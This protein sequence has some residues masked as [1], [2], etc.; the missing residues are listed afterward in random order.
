MP[1]ITVANRYIL[2]REL[3]SGGMGVVHCALDKL[4]NIQVALKRIKP[5]AYTPELI[6]RFKREG[7]VLHALKHPNIIQILDAF[8][9]DGQHYLVMSYLPGGNL[10]QLMKQ[11][12]LDSETVIRIGLD[13]ADAL[14]QAH[15]LKIIHRDLKPEN[16]LLDE[17]GTPFLTDFGLAQVESSERLTTTGAILGT[18]DYLP[19]EAFSDV[20]RNEK[21]DIWSLGVL[22]V[23]LLTGENPFARPNMLQTIWAITS[24]PRPNLESAMKNTPAGM[25]DLIYRMLERNPESRIPSMRHVGASLEEIVRG[26]VVSEDKSRFATPVSKRL[27][28]AKHNLPLQ[29]TPFIGRQQEVQDLVT[30]LQK[31]TQRIISIVGPGG[32]GK[33]RIMLEVASQSMSN[34]VD[35]IFFVQLAS[36]RSSEGLIPAVAEAFGYQ[37]QSDTRDQRTQLMG[38]LSDKHLLLLLDNAEHLPEIA[39][40]VTDILKRAPKVYILVSSRQRLNHSSETLFQL[41]TLAY[42]ADVPLND[43]DTTNYSALRLFLDSA[44][45]VRPEFE[46]TE[47]NAEAVVRICQQIDGLPLGI[48]LAA[49]WL[50][51]L[52]VSEIADELRHSVD[53][54]NVDLVDLPERHRGMRAVF[55]SSWKLLT[56]EEQEVFIRLSIFQGSFTREAAQVITS[57]RL[58]TLSSLVNKSLI[59][60]DIES[61]YFSVHELVRQ[62][63]YEKLIAT[64]VLLPIQ[65]AHR[66]YYLLLMANLVTPLRTSGQ[67]DALNK[68]EEAF[69]N[70]RIAWEQAISDAQWD[71]LGSASESLFHLARIR[72]RHQDT[73]R[74]F[75]I[76]ARYNST[77]HLGYARLL[78]WYA[79]VISQSKQASIDL[80][81]AHQQID[82]A[83]AIF[84]KLDVTINAQDLWLLTYVQ[85]SL[86]ILDRSENLVERSNRLMELVGDSLWY[87]ALT[88]HLQG[89]VDAQ[90]GF[91]YTQQAYVLFR[92]LGNIAWT[93][94]QANNL[95]VWMMAFD[96]YALA[97]IFLDECIAAYQSLG[98]YERVAHSLGVR[99][100]MFLA[101]GKFE[102]ARSDYNEAKPIAKRI[103]NVYA[104]AMAIN[105]LGLL[106][107]V[108]G[109]LQMAFRLAQRTFDLLADIPRKSDQDMALVVAGFIKILSGRSTDP[110]KILAKIGPH[111]SYLPFS[112]YHWFFMMAAIYLLASESEKTLAAEL[113]GALY[114]HG[115]LP[116]GF[117]HVLQPTLSVLYEALGAQAYEE[118]WT[119]GEKIADYNRT[120]FGVVEKFCSIGLDD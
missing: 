117:R 7:D 54:L 30:L 110:Y 119:S 40:L 31:G 108:D 62:Y 67:L 58:H 76:A 81:L 11:Q 45:R 60:R 86:E 53:I 70:I 69:E 74:M 52:S 50:N 26:N 27:D 20:P 61:G 87:R 85:I 24:E 89:Y 23:E 33:T 41:G 42:P 102:Q 103:S 101:L 43:I 63:G 116:K 106:A 16:V 10:R 90:D 22:L 113:G 1:D 64:E 100:N 95:A 105:G 38:F 35:G 72:N 49:N 5:E 75:E 44:R 36:L 57:C 34:F 92:K 107:L 18:V 71:L 84:D 25:I 73:R 19:P 4:T 8:E 80:P 39:E 79:L 104:L 83:A 94:I 88:R 120:V 111:I 6:T 118:A 97:K 9:D 112:P 55:D 56:P 3:G 115:L 77:S 2:Q 15:K 28:H 91:Q 65:A 93:A 114:S 98:D 96:Q 59:Q 21:G 48:V 32:V 99:G 109:D 51:M 14:T 47:N 37:F 82:L 12:G 13:L 66:D 78:L 29:T 46:I 17:K 68:I